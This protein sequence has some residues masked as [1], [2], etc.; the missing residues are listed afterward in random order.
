MCVYM[1]SC[2][3]TF[4]CARL[5]E[6]EKLEAVPSLSSMYLHLDQFFYSA[7][8]LLRGGGKNYCAQVR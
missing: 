6:I 2:I 1:Y 8:E 7:N 5:G 3:H 4:G